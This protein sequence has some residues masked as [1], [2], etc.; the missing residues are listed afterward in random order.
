ME[1]FGELAR[2]A[3]HAIHNCNIASFNNNTRQSANQCSE[4]LTPRQKAKHETNGVTR[5]VLSKCVPLWTFPSQ[6]IHGLVNGNLLADP[7]RV[8]E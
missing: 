5:S 8:F 3:G 7:Q 6:H 4:F 1:R 2:K